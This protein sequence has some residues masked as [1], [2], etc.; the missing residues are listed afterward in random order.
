MKPLY[1]K[2]LKDWTDGEAQEL[3]ATVKFLE[4]NAHNNMDVIMGLMK[5]VDA[6]AR[7]VARLSKESEAK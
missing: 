3:A 2:R 4:N 6:L 5:K 7:E 1:N